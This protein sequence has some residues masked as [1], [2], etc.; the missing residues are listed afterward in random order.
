MDGVFPLEKP[1][2]VPCQGLR[3]FQSSFPE[4]AAYQL[5]EWADKVKRDNGSPCVKKYSESGQ[6]KALSNSLHCLVGVKNTTEEKGKSKISKV[7]SM[8]ICGF[9]ISMPL[10]NTL[11]LYI[12][13]YHPSNHFPR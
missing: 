7:I 6:G 13:L 10:L 1:L 12:N 3:L 9:L 8:L 11:I 5:M 2:T 4:E